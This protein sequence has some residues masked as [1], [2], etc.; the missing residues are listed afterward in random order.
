MSSHARFSPASV[1]VV[2]AA[3]A[4]LFLLAAA[5]ADPQ[6]AAETRYLAFWSTAVLLCAAGLSRQPSFELAGSTILL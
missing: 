1:A 6:A 3:G 4:S 2:L 5:Q